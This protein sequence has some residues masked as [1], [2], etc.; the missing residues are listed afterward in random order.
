[1]NVATSRCSVTATYTISTVITLLQNVH[2]RWERR[3]KKSLKDSWMS[4]FYTTPAQRHRF[5][6]ATRHILITGAIVVS[7]HM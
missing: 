6:Q 5:V 1:M 2:K 4:R 7:P 3:Q